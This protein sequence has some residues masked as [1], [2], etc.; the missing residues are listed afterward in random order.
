MP[1]KRDP[2]ASCQTWNTDCVSRLTEAYIIILD[3][4]EA[5]CQ[6]TVQKRLYFSSAAKPPTR[7][8]VFHNQS[9]TTS[10]HGTDQRTT[11]IA[12][13]NPIATQVIHRHTLQ[14]QL[15]KLGCI[16]RHLIDL[17]AVELFYISQDS[18]VLHSYKIDG[19]TL[20]AEAA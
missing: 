5:F 3:P 7:V 8:H 6:P 4:L 9:L 18:H 1:P 2:T 17:C 12:I 20:A 16:H 14:Y 13:Q 11:E 15:N 19:H 10:Q